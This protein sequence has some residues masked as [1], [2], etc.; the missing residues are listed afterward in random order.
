MAI[1]LEK[2]LYIQNKTDTKIIESNEF[3]LSSCLFTCSLQVHFC[4]LSNRMSF[5]SKFNDNLSTYSVL[6][7]N[8]FHISFYYTCTLVYMYTYMQ[9]TPFFC[10][11]TDFTVS[12]CESEFWCLT[13]LSVFV[14][15]CVVQYLV[16]LYVY[17]I[18]Y[19]YYF[20]C[21]ICNLLYC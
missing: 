1:H 19:R 12:I 21:P 17:L 11:A 4:M 20:L 3:R 2:K 8:M 18:F 16:I 15:V 14:G 10:D 6:S 5:R 13:P 9:Q 7:L